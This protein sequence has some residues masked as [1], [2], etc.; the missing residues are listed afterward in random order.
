MKR[1]L[2][3]LVLLSLLLGLAPAALA[4]KVIFASFSTDRLVYTPGTEKAMLRV[5]LIK[6]ADRDV[7]LHF[8]D[9]RGNRC[10]VTVPAKKTEAEINVAQY[11]PTDGS[12]TV[13]TLENGEDYVRRNPWDCVASPRGMTSYSFGAEAFQGYVGRELKVRLNVENAGKLA[14]GTKITLRDAQGKVLEAFEHSRRRSSWS[15]TYTPDDSWRPGGPVYVWVEGRDT[16]DASS[17]IVAG[18]Y[19]ARTLC[20]VQRTDNK[21]AFT[22]DAGSGGGN[23]PTILEILRRHNL[24]ITFFITG[25][26]AVN[27]PDYV[28]MIAAEGHEIAN[29]SWSHP[30]FYDLTPAKI[31]SEVI[32]TRDVLEGLTGQTTLYFRPP[33][34]H[35]NSQIRALIDAA[36]FEVIRWTHDSI[37]SREGATSATS[38][39]FATKN[40]VPGSIILTHVNADWT[41]AVLDEILTWYEENGFEVVKVSE[42]LLE[43]NTAT[44]ENGLQYIAAP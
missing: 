9:G 1:I 36:G 40:I 42:L 4:E 24:K 43:G 20:G 8:T 5:K 19:G 21:I 7:T 3:I 10:E 41:V 23:T 15:F 14:D 29:H 32:R 12:K 31:L 28:R 6:A 38:L 30:S 13:F 18:V 39:R 25:Q 35:C 34:G 16:P 37:D 22:M 33:K 2:C 26:F 11:L 44:D 17:V 27:Y